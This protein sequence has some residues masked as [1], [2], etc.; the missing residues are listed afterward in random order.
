MET[1]TEAPKAQTMEVLAPPAPVDTAFLDLL[2]L[3]RGGDCLD[4]LGKAL[5]E[6]NTA[7]RH[8]G[9]GGIV[10]LRIGVKPANGGIGAVAVKDE[11]K[12]ALPKVD[13]GGSLFYMNGNDGLQKEDPN[14]RHLDL[15]VVSGGPSDGAAELKRVGP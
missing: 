9:K 14:Q 15:K 12:L 5:R 3:H 10:T 11:I 13:K 8:T 4:E 7:I 6:V 1:K 2:R